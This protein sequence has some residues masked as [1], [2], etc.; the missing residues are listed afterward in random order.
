[1][2][3]SDE[4]TLKIK[5]KLTI[6][7][8][9]TN[10]VT[11]GDTAVFTVSVN[12]GT[13]PYT[14][15][16]Q[17]WKPSDQTWRSTAAATNFGTIENADAK[18]TL[19]LEATAAR[20]GYKIRCKVTDADSLVNT[21]DEVTLKIKPKVTTTPSQ[22]IEVGE[23][24]KATIR[25]AVSGGSQNYTYQWKYRTSSSGTWYTS[26]DTTT[27]T[28]T[29]STLTTSAVTAARN[30]YQFKCVVTDNTTGLTGESA[31]VTLRVIPVGVTV[32][33]SPTNPVDEG[34][35][36]VFTAH[37][38]GGTGS[39]TYRWKYQAPNDAADTWTNCTSAHGTGYTSATLRVPAERTW[40]GYKYKCVVTD[41]NTKKTATSDATELVVLTVRVVTQ[42]VGT[43]KNPGD[44]VTLTVEIEKG[45]APYTYQWYYAPACDANDTHQAGMAVTNSLLSNAYPFT[46]PANSCESRWYHCVITD[47]KGNTAVTEQVLVQYRITASIERTP[48]GDTVSHGTTVTMT[49]KVQGGAKLK[50]QSG[51]DRYTY[52]WY[53]IKQGTTA[54]TEVGTGNTYTFTMNGDKL[55]TYFF[56]VTDALGVTKES[57][58]DAI[59]HN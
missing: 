44:A 10:E 59:L 45:T 24:L 39:Y 31:P 22:K 40:N 47:S 2:N 14:Y 13:K 23:G 58:R 5:P 18:T 54:K 30:G 34:G 48:S 28:T 38:S 56:E 32:T 27:E 46:V 21:S 9:P 15:Q 57:S 35:T 36:A 25:A 43:T 12:G 41:T 6:T 3:T 17:Y 55:G 11:A 52:V 42:P 26:S 19:R 20:N 37:A 53:F 4:V 33:P 1:M 49:A 16:W 29:T 50:A 7:P 51:A 8:K